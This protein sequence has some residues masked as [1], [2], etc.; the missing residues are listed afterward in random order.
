M[1]SLLGFYLRRKRRIAESNKELFDEV[2]QDF[3]EGKKKA[4]NELPTF[5]VRS[6][7]VDLCRKDNKN[8]ETVPPGYDTAMR[9]DKSSAAAS[10]DNRFSAYF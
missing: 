7:S 2:E 10:D 3:G 8:L 5:E 4:P 6:A 9:R 1:I